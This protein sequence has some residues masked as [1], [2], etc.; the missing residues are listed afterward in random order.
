[1]A[2]TCWPNLSPDQEPR[3]KLLL[4]LGPLPERAPVHDGG[5]GGQHTGTGSHSSEGQNVVRRGTHSASC[6]AV[7]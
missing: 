2:F 5:E 3:S 6:P 7:T 4:S 1:M